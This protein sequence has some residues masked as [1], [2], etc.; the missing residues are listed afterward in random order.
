LRIE[1]AII[2]DHF[3]RT[4]FKRIVEK[5]IIPKC[6]NEFSASA[7]KWANYSDA[8]VTSTSATEQF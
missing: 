6:L 1:N 3:T 5:T 7:S 8:K 2:G 4:D